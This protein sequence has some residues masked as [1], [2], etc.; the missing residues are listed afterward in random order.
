MPTAKALLQ[1]VLSVTG[2]RDI[3]PLH[4]ERFISIATA[5]SVDRPILHEVVQSFLKTSQPVVITNIT[6][7]LGILCLK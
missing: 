5:K 3:A 1:C 2:A 7:Q 4:K 6:F